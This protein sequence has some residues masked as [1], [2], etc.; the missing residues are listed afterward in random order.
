MLAKHSESF[1]LID[2]ISVGVDRMQR[3]FEPM[4]QKV[5]GSAVFGE[6]TADAIVQEVRNKTC[7]SIP[8]CGPLAED[9][10]QLLGGDSG[11]DELIGQLPWPPHMKQ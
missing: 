7:L 4:R 9:R 3:N 11:C 10:V 8:H 1:P 6:S 2:C 5:E